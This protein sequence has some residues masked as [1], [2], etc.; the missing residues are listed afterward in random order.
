MI[1]WRVV[2]A[3]MPLHPG[4]GNP[5]YARSAAEREIATA[6]DAEEWE[7]K[8]LATHERFREFWTAERARNPRSFIPALDRWF[9]DG[10]YASPPMVKPVV[11]VAEQRREA[12]R[13]EIEAM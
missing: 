1:A 4:R 5:Q 11:S 3:L 12:L 13:R 6:P 10:D 2:D 8:V 9:S 7:R